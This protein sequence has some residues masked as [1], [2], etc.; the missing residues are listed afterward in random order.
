M[1]VNDNLTITKVER[2]DRGHSDGYGQP[3]L[4]V[5]YE[6]VRGRLDLRSR[7]RRNLDGT[8]A[9]ID[10]TIDISPN[11]W[12]KPGDLLTF[13]YGWERQFKVFDV[14][15]AMDASGVPLFRT[16]LLTEMR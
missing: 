15:E 5:A 1:T 9:Q 14:E 2:A 12:L 11:L 4:A 8:E 16:Y 3:K 13:T 7:I 10:A 6:G